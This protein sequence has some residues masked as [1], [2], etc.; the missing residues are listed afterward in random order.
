MGK[1]G[2]SAPGKKVRFRQP[3]KPGQVR[4]FTRK[5]CRKFLSN[6]VVQFSFFFA[7]IGLLFL[8]WPR[9]SVYPGQTVDPYKPFKTPFIVKNDG[10]LPI[11]NIKLSML[12]KDVKTADGSV[13]GIGSRDGAKNKEDYIPVL[14]RDASYPFHIKQ[15]GGIAPSSLQSEDV[16]III[17]YR[18]Y[19]IPF[20]LTE[21]K[22]FE[23]AKDISGKYYWSENHI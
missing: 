2:R 10:Y 16:E 6:V 1:K 15:A 4:L 18:P 9:L 5:R 11:A 19:L 12:V 7:V 8:I 17:S 21:T 22:S 3:A 13:G 23:T 20:T 14:R